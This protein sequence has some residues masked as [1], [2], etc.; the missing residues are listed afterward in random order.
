LDTP[1]QATIVAVALVVAD[2]SDD[3]R[4]GRS[5]SAMLLCQ[6]ARR[7]AV[8]VVAVDC[9]AARSSVIRQR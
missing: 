8:S 7:V 2:V 1:S 9:S 5:S 6:A 3:Q 4:W